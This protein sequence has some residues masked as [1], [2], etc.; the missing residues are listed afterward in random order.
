MTPS[1]E[2]CKDCPFFTIKTYGNGLGGFPACTHPGSGP[3]V[4]NELDQMDDCPC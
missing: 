2:N 3:R 4:A 1:E